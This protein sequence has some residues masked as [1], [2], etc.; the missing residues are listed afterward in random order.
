MMKRK[1]K[2]IEKSVFIGLAT[3]FAL[4]TSLAQPESIVLEDDPSAP[5]N[6]QAITINENATFITESYQ[7]PS[8]NLYNK[9]WNIESVAHEKLSIPFSNQQLKIVLTQ[10]DS[11]FYF[12]CQGAITQPFSNKAK[13]QHWGID[14]QT[15]ANDP[16]VACFDGVVRLVRQF[17]QYGNVIV[18]RHYNGLETIYAHLGLVNVKSGQR[19]Q[20]GELIGTCNIEDDY[21][22]FETR[23]FYQPFNPQLFI[24]KE[25]HHLLS[26][27]L[28][29]TPLDMVESPT[30]SAIAT[31]SS[32]ST[33]NSS[34]TT[35]SANIHIVKAGDTLYKISRQYNVSVE[36]I[37]QINHLKESAILSL[38][39]KIRIR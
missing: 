6:L 9:S 8:Y 39:Q 15:R 24:D 25:T 31:S 21:L 34:A 26:D 14:I 16:V 38:G 18:I 10:A 36:K 23:F 17:D 33:S 2:F 29:L 12:P 28:V 32:N 22:H 20:A 1:L 7:I 37:L 3:F 27:T 5:I 19:I 13:K 35:S 4:A 11:P 30:T